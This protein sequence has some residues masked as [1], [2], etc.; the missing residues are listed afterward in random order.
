MSVKDYSQL[1]TWQ[2]AMDLAEAVYAATRG[3]PK[4]EMY[5]LTSQTRRSAVSVPSNI[6]EG[7][8]RGSSRDFVRFLAVARGSLCELETQL[9]LGGRLKY[10]DQA[11]VS[12]LLKQAATV[13]RLINGLIRS[14]AP[15]AEHR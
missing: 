10:M 9:L 12:T 8:G 2:R 15:P 13:G 6:A 4:D 11:S 7:Q 1:E 5:G 3:Y 14:V